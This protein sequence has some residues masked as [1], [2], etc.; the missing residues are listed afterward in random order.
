MEYIEFIEFIRR[1]IKKAGKMS[2]ETKKNLEVTN[3]GLNDIVT[4]MDR[5]I[6]CFLESSI[7]RYYPNHNIISEENNTDLSVVQNSNYSWII[8]PLDGTVNYVHQKINFTIAIALCKNNEP[9][10]SGIYDPSRDEFFYAI[11]NK[12]A[13]LNDKKIFM[14]HENSLQECLLNVC[15]NQKNNPFKQPFNVRGIRQLGSAS[16]ELAYIAAGR[17][18]IFLYD[19]LQP[20]DFVAG[21]LLIE[22]AGGIIT[23]AYGK[24]LT[25]NNKS[26]VLATSQSI[27]QELNNYMN[28]KTVEE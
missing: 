6:N 17:L 10:I 1:I 8:D 9:M 2:L 3:K 7:N 12:G 11:K 28:L 18:D 14:K 13:F 27:Y 22:E 21:K 20:W 24:K 23:T 25:I 15:W 16:L 4:S 5:D 26:S 19:R